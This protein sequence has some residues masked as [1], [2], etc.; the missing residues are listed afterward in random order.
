MIGIVFGMSIVAMSS[1]VVIFFTQ[2]TTS[3]TFPQEGMYYDICCEREI[4]LEFDDIIIENAC[5][6]VGSCPVPAEKF[7]HALKTLLNDDICKE[8]TLTI[9]E[10]LEPS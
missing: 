5:Q 4:P 10:R 9:T 6:C 8:E 1:A 3:I 2:Q 7:N